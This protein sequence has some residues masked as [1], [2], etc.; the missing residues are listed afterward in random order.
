MSRPRKHLRV[1]L[2]SRPTSIGLPV[3]CV[4]EGDEA[5]LSQLMFAAYRGSIDDDG[6]SLSDAE[7]SVRTTLHGGHGY[8]LADC[9]FVALDDGHPAAGTL[10]T[11]LHGEPVL[12]QVGTAPTRKRRGLARA[13]IQLSMNAL[14]ARGETELSLVVTSGNEP[15]ERLYQDFGFS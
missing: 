12:S 11:M 15:A 7:Q 10:V 6:E 13:L 14:V 4:H 5:D 8:F 1:E 9:S 2:V 3:R